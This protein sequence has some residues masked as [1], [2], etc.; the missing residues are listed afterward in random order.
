[1]RLKRLD[2]FQGLI[3]SFGQI[4]KSCVDGV[5]FGL[6]AGAVLLMSLLE[7]GFDVVAEFE[8]PL[9]IILQRHEDG[10]GS[11]DKRRLIQHM[12]IIHGAQGGIGSDQAD[13]GGDDDDRGPDGFQFAVL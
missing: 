8:L 10:V 11:R 7:F 5:K 3:I 12:L 9:F 2:A 6:Q 4:G 13:D 1:L